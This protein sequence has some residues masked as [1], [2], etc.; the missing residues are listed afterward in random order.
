VGA[1][2]GAT[3]AAAL[4][5]RPGTAPPLVVMVDEFTWPAQMAA[6]AFLFAL[7]PDAVRARA[8]PLLGSLRALRCDGGCGS[9]RCT[10][11]SDVLQT[12]V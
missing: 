5:A 11:V 9:S 6:N 1:G 4:T 3:A 8:G 2:V 7:R 12:P 10:F